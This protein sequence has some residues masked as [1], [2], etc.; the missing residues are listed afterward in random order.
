MNKKEI[1]GVFRRLNL[2]ADFKEQAPVLLWPEAIGER[3]AASS[4]ALHVKDGTLHVRVTS[5]TAGEEIR[6]KSEGLIKRLNELSGRPVVRRIKIE[7]G[8]KGERPD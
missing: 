2:L 1:E 3:L 7:V 4:A 5:S 6:L 8:G